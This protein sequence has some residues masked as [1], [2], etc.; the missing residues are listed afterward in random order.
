MKKVLTMAFY[1]FFI[2]T[3][4]IYSGI[5]SAYTSPLNNITIRPNPPPL[6][7]PNH[8][9]SNSIDTAKPPIQGT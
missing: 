2:S 9:A 7:T 1:I 4:A 3:C 6:N 8:P 5:S